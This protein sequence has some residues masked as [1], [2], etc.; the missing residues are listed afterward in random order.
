MPSYKYSVDITNIKKVDKPNTIEEK[1]N[2]NLHY[3]FHSSKKGEQFGIDL[4]RSEIFVEKDG[5]VI[6]LNKSIASKKI[7]NFVDDSNRDIENFIKN[8]GLEGDLK[9]E[10]QTNLEKVKNDPTKINDIITKFLK[11][12]NLKYPI[13][14]EDI[15]KELKDTYQLSDSQVDVI[16]ACHA[17]QGLASGFNVL[18]SFIVPSQEGLISSNQITTKIVIDKD[19]VKCKNIGAAIIVPEN[20]I[21]SDPNRCQAIKNEQTEIG[22]VA[23]FDKKFDGYNK[24]YE[25]SF[26]DLGKAGDNVKSIKAD[27]D[28]VTNFDI[29]FKSNATVKKE[30]EIMDEFKD[31]DN[32][33]NVAILLNKF[34]SNN[35]NLNSEENSILN[36]FK[37]NDVVKNEMFPDVLIK[38][39][40]KE[41]KN[42]GDNIVSLDKVKE[43]AEKAAN[44]IENFI[45]KD[46]NKRFLQ[47]EIENVIIKSNNTEKKPNWDRFKEFLKSI[48]SSHSRDVEN[49]LK[50]AKKIATNMKGKAKIAGVNGGNKQESSEQKPMMISRIR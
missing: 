8:I 5:N 32:S 46:M 45:G 1:I 2:N 9:K 26:I 50:E 20:M 44:K 41:V 39:I 25:T 34:L 16:K 47:T 36:M 21:N 31:F 23:I 4:N 6:N 29:A 37:K 33:V 11:D 40:E 35:E 15:N 43:I 7:K 17:Q 49:V 10:L 13:T 19:N 24:I 3:D 28:I 12:N 27:I 48:F 38:H 30:K 22:R 14:V 42:L 18:G